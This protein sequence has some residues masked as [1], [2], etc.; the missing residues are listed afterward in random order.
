MSAWD[1]FLGNIQSAKKALD[2]REDEECFY[3]G[4]SDKTWRLEPTLL[5]YGRKRY[6]DESQESNKQKYKKTIKQKYKKTIRKLECDLYSEFKIR[7]HALH[8]G[9]IPESWDLFF[10]MRHHHVPT[11]LLDWSEVL[12][13]SVFFAINWPKPDDQPGIWLLNPYKLNEIS[14]ERDLAAPDWLGDFSTFKS[15]KS[16]YEDFIYNHGGR[17]GFDKPIGVYPTQ[18]NPRLRAQGG[19]FTIHGDDW[20]PLD[21]A[22]PE[23][24]RFVELPKTAIDDARE[25]LSRA[26]INDFS[27]YP[28]ADGLARFLC[29]KNNL[30]INFEKL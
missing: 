26:G 4:V 5:Y 14:G 8:N 12:G 10:M 21:V 24:L 27:I 23:C 25:F 7:S 30:K 6:G 19:Y 29:R 16:S 9:R 1:T 17:F 20:R 11:R 15:D 22:A 18:S 2:F 13:V 28:D 3:R